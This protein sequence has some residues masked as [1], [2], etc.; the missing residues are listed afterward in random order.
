VLSKGVSA[1]FGKMLKSVV[2]PGPYVNIIGTDGSGKTTALESLKDKLAYA[3]VPSV[4][5][6]EGRH[7]FK[8]LPINFIFDRV[9]K[10]K[11][12]ESMKENKVELNAKDIRYSSSLARIASPVLYYFEYLLRYLFMIYPKRLKY[13][14]LLSDRGYLDVLVSPNANQKVARFCYALLPKPDA[15]I[16]L[17]NKPEILAKRKPDHPAEDI[18]RQL[19]IY[20]GLE[21][22]FDLKVLTDEKEDTVQKCF[23]KILPLM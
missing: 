9:V 17:Y 7:A 2:H 13:D 18:K 21:R 19:E 8:I 3:R 23:E 20:K 15:V 14:V 4:S 11:K 10:K 6:Y 5:S 22:Y 1:K 16:F 12:D